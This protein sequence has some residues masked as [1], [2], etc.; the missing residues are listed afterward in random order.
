MYFELQLKL[1]LKKI[2]EQKQL[3]FDSHMHIIILYIIYIYTVQYSCLSQCLNISLLELSESS[4]VGHDEVKR[5]KQ[6][7][8]R[9]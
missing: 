3:L 2:H 7:P 6:P 9:L 5:L 8:L 1:T 4:N